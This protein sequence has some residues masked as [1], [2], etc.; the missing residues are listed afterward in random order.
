MILRVF[1]VVLGIAAIAA[2]FSSKKVRR[3]LGHGDRALRGGVA[4]ASV[5]GAR[6]AETRLTRRYG[7]DE[8]RDIVDEASW[9]SFPAS[10][11]PAW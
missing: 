5:L 8:D 4:A 7:A 11:P 6:E 9:E 3:R 10:D 1:T 2:Y